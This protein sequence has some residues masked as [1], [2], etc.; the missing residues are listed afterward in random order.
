MVRINADVG[1]GGWKI[2]N[3]DERNIKHK[4]WPTCQNPFDGFIYW[5]DISGF[6]PNN[7]VLDGDF[8]RL[9]AFSNLN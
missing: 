2:F 6:G 3:S 1:D 9:N 7:L 4:M 5:S 8:T